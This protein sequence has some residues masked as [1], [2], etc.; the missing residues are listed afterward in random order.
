MRPIERQ[1]AGC[2][3]R[4]KLFENEG[5]TF[6]SFVLGVVNSAAFRMAKGADTPTLTTDAA[7]PRRSNSSAR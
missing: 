1:S 3:P 2:D 7:E 6:S 4:P 5:L